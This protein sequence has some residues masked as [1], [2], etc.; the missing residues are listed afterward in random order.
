MTTTRRKVV[1]RALKHVARLRGPR[2]SLLL[3][4][5]RAGWILDDVAHEL[6]ANVPPALRCRVVKQEWTGARDCTIHFINR[7]WAWTDG[8]LDASDPSNRLI[9]LWWHGRLDSPEP[10]MQAALGRLRTLH[11]R[12]DRLQVTCSIARETLLEIGVPAEKIVT[13]PEGVSVKTFH[14]P[15]ADA[16]RAAARLQL[17]IPPDAFVV[18]CFQ[19][20]GE[21]WN[22][23]CVPK[24]IKGPDVL[25]DALVR[26][27]AHR[28]IHAL[29]PGPARGYVTRRLTE[30]GVPAC[31]PGLV[32]RADLPR[33]YHALD[34]YVSPS[35]DEGGPAGVLEA[36]ASGV[37]VV[38]T[39]TGM[40]ADLIEHGVSGFITRVDDSD[41]LADSAARL[42]DDEAMR[43]AIGKHGRARV[44]ALDWEVLARRY[45]S[46]L[47]AP[48]VA[49]YGLAER[50]M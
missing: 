46:E 12:F 50:R 49:G 24:L 28:P 31:A 14:P 19:K 42:A 35:R 23:G 36:M 38:S 3:V 6:H 41:G 39:R 5:D 32:P 2:R 34:V 17:G 13:L 10:A 7:T 29:L 44:K 15:A 22:D 37:P 8:V 4:V 30:A 26:L 27:H 18:G 1:R 20:D 21:G 47:Y 33:L 43:R 40:A 9:G 25:V 16:D 48:V 45:V 11:P